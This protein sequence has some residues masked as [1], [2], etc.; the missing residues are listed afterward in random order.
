MM[1]ILKIIAGPLIGFFGKSSNRFA[2]LQFAAAGLAVWFFVHQYNDLQDARDTI[3]TERAAR[4]AA[5]E[6]TIE[7]VKRAERIAAARDEAQRRLSERMKAVN[8][9]RG[10]CLEKELP[11]GLLDQ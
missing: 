3:E 9:A 11:A 5:E 6:A 10:E 1:S 4:V 7:A 2:L 8:E